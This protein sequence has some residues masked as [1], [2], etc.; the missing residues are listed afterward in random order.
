MRVFN[1]CLILIGL[2]N[3]PAQADESVPAHL[4]RLPSSV[5]TAFVAETSAAAFHRFDNVAHRQLEYRGSTEMS[6]G[7]NG[8][9]KQRNGDQRTPLGIYFVTEQL[10]TTRM[11]E[12]YGVTAYVLDYPNTWDRRMQRTGD[13]IW[14]HGVDSRGGERPPL[15][16]DGCIALPNE[17]L[18]MLSDRFVANAT[19]VL[20]G[21][22]VNW[23]E[24]E[25]VDAL[26]AELE[27]TVSRWADSLQ[28]GDLHAYLSLYDDEFRHWS[29]NKDEWI[30]FRTETLASRP[31]QK[32]TIDD[33]LL[34]GDPVENELYLSRFRLVTNESTGT[35]EVTKRL[36]WQRTGA[37]A[38]KII[39]EDSG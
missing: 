37:G 13:G 34:L 30:A 10:D 1:C 3:I 15:D 31:I 28:S 17:T 8:D 6:I 11:H 33:L 5:T 7:R 24:Q 22:K 38:L 16:T 18:K 25:E 4:I 32:V 36:Y 35:L 20:I 19:P 29:M 9:G 21:K 14:V 27:E 23:V 26:R 12:K 39:A 2:A